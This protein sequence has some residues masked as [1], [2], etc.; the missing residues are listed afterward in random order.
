M[1]TLPSNVSYGTVVGRYLI[2]YQDGIDV[3][4]YPDGVPCGGK[5]FFTPSVTSLRNATSSPTPVTILPRPVTCELDSDG[6]LNGPDG[7]PGVRLIATDDEDNE[8]VDWTWRVDYQ[9]TDSS[10]MALRGI[11]S[12]NISLNGGTTLDLITVSPVAGLV[13]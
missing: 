12:H 6:Y 9:L 7:T 1:T 13:G 5:I 4:V 11:G 3:D 2:A 10:G 8:P